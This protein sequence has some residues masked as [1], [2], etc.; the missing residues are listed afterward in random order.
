MYSYYVCTYV[1]T[2]VGTYIVWIH[3]YIYMYVCIYIYI[4]M[5][6]AKHNDE[7]LMWAFKDRPHGFCHPSWAQKAKPNTK[8][9]RLKDPK[10]QTMK[11]F[12]MFLMIL[13]TCLGSLKVYLRNCW[14]IHGISLWPAVAQ[15]FRSRGA[16]LLFT[17]L[18]GEAEGRPALVVFQVA[19][20]SIFFHGKWWDGEKS[21]W[22]SKKVS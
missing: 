9:D 10:P 14:P 7:P 3:R 5:D 4:R 18:W 21:W 12:R 6:R 11:G 2:Y 8:N 15:K 16:K 1:R 13:M 17:H 20:H 22:F 19:S